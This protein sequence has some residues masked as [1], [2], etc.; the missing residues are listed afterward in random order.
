MWESGSATCDRCGCEVSTGKRN[1]EPAEEL[2][3]RLRGKR[4]KV[5]DGVLACA[6]CGFGYKVRPEGEPDASENRGPGPSPVEVSAMSNIREIARQWAQIILP[7]PATVDPKQ[8]AY[9]A[10]HAIEDAARKDATKRGAPTE[11]DGW[12]RD[13]GA[14]RTQLRIAIMKRIEASRG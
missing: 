6:N 9:K 13:V 10:A 2:R 8:D 14:W 4:A 7:D 1:D 11:P 12:Y 5:R 3:A